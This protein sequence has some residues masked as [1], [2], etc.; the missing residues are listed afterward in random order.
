MGSSKLG[1]SANSA[2]IWLS[3]FKVCARDGASPSRFRLATAGSVRDLSDKSKM[4]SR[5][6][7]IGCKF[8]F[9]EIFARLRVYLFICGD[10]ESNIMIMIMYE[11]HS[12]YS[13]YDDGMTP[14]LTMLYIHLVTSIKNP[15]TMITLELSKVLPALSVCNFKL[16]SKHKAT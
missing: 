1:S 4:S 2:T 10:D 7:K 12:F 3:G 16:L 8:G 9:M 13:L 11:Q 5:S 15:Y 6:S 14:I